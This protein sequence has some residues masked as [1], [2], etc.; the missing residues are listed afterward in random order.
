MAEGIT[1]EFFD[2]KKFN[3]SSSTTIVKIVSEEL[4]LD[5]NNNPKSYFVMQVYF[6]EH[7]EPLK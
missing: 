3:L 6:K 7:Q 1:H 5:Q 2:T 4:R